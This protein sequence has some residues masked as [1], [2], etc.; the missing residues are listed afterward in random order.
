MKKVLPLVL[1]SFLLCGVVSAAS[2]YGEYKGHQIIKVTANGTALKPVD[3]PAIELDDRTMVPVS[4][5]EQLGVQVNW[6][7]QNQTVDVQM[8]KSDS[9][10]KKK[11]AE[12]ADYYIELRDLSDYIKSFTQ[13]MN[14]F[15]TAT[16]NGNSKLTMQDLLTEYQS[17]ADA[18][19][20]AYNDLLKLPNE[21]APITDSKAYPQLETFAKSMKSYGDALVKLGLYEKSFVNY[22][23]QTNQILSDYFQLMSEGNK[24]RQEADVVI[25]QQYRMY[26]D[27]VIS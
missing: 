20:K 2:L 19:K 12:L 11:Y 25:Q 22:P 15:Q 23:E 6:D 17:T 10:D 9:S 14:Y 27:K 16:A 24:S 4:L 13:E 18:N 3:V 7:G 26:M 8:P 5:L 21:T 1:L